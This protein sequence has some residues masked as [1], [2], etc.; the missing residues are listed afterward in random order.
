MYDC[1]TSFKRPNRR[2][3]THEQ[4]IRFFVMC[5]HVLDP[6]VRETDEELREDL[7][8]HTA[9]GIVAVY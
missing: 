7:K 4:Y 5:R 1:M 2:W 6:D 8:V 9:V 3:V